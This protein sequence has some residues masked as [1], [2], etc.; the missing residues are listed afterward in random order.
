MTS[1]RNL[2][3]PD[4]HAGLQSEVTVTITPGGDG[5]ELRIRHKNLTLP[6]AAKRHAEGWQGAL[7]RLPKC[8]GS[9]NT[10]AGEERP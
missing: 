7:D 5:A 8:P 1:A 2:E 9:R 6:G 10:Q 3:P 4:E